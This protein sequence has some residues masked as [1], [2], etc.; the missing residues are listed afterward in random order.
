MESKLLTKDC[1]SI[2][3]YLANKGM[4]L[5]NAPRCRDCRTNCLACQ[6]AGRM[7][8]NDQLILKKMKKNLKQVTLQ[9]GSKQFVA[10]Y[11]LNCDPIKV[12]YCKHSNHNEAHRQ[13]TCNYKRLVS[14]QD[15]RE[16]AQ[17]LLKRGVEYNHFKVL[18]SEET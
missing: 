7:T 16:A 11:L 3:R 5:R 17:K 12:F 4:V 9:D 6:K 15:G 8:P 2:N 18:S 13:A 10:S 14:A 1:I